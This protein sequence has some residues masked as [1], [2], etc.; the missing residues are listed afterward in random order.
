MQGEFG[1]S[2]K[3]SRPV[4]DLHRRALPATLELSFVASLFA[5]FVGVPMGVYTAL[6]RESWLSNASSSPYR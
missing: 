2:Y 4:V 6:N 3:H 5:L 1:I